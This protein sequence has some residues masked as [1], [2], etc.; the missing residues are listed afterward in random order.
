M[1]LFYYKM[2]AK[3]IALARFNHQPEPFRKIEFPTLQSIAIEVVAANFT[4]YPH[5]SGLSE[6]M[7]QT[8]VESID[9]VDYL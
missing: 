8:V 9:W 5:L 4:E 6:G 1:N 3:K 7:K 2:L